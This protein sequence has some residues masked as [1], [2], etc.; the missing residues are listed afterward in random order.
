MADLEKL[1]PHEKEEDIVE[2]A[3]RILKVYGKVETPV[4]DREI[5]RMAEMLNI[6]IE[7]VFPYG[8]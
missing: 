3:K 2:L 5:V 6:P 7:E 8:G 4:L 1:S